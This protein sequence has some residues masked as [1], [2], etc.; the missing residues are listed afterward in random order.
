MP[1]VISEI[2]GCIYFFRH[3]IATSTLLYTR[4]IALPFEMKEMS[5]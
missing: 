5:S 4:I 3:K 2:P 1:C